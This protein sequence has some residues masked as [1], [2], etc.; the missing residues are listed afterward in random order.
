MALSTKDL[1]GGASVKKTIAPGKHTLKVNSVELESFRFKEDAYHLILNLE[2]EPLKDFEGFL[3]DVND[4]SKGTYKGQVGKVKTS[5]YAYADGETPSGIKINRDRSILMFLKGFCQTLAMSEEG[6][7]FKTWFTDQDGKYENI[8]AFVEAFNAEIQKNESIY[9]DFCVG[10][11]EYENKSGYINYD[12]F[13]VK[14]MNGKYP[15]SAV[16]STKL[17]DYD[18]KNPYHLIILKV[19]DVESFGDDDTLNIKSDASNDFSLD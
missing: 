15:Y 14:P 10:G 6:K 9:L 3:I 19:K 4:S 12:L 11:K 8:E 18:E 2:T 16:D 17:V 1:Q 13:L 7:T 5:R